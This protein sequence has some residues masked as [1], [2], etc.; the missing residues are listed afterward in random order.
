MIHDAI[1]QVLK[2]S[3]V[4]TGAAPGAS[5]F[6]AAE[7]GGEWHGACGSSGVRG[8]AHPAPVGAETI[9]DFASLTKPLVAATVARLVRSGVVEWHTPLGELL[10]LARGTPSAGASLD[11]LLSHR[12]GL[13]AHL[14]LGVEWPAAGVEHWLERCALARRGDCA[15]DFPAEG[16]PP[17]YSDLGYILLGAALEVAV[18]EPLS[19]I[20]LRELVTPLRLDLGSAEQ[21][22]RRLGVQAF[23]ERVAPTETIEARGGELLGVVHDDNAWDLAG[24]RLAGHAGAFG[25]AEA[26]GRFGTAVLSALEG[27]SDWLEA[28]LVQRLVRPRAGGSL[29][30]GFDAKAP[31]G[32]SAGARFGPKAFGHLGFT[33]TSVWCDP[34]ARVVV[35]LLTNRVCPSRENILIRTIRPHVHDALFGLAAGLRS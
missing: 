13:D 18:G 7:V 30:A 27:R 6:V 21:W 17:V 22:T 24:R 15:G 32:S 19:D 26:M 20:V 9:Y 5:A 33:G 34:E 25:T 14:R 8:S 1:S 28:P 29:L 11:L 23:E 16:F 10:P 2:R 12:A 35:V 3:V 4:E 31:A